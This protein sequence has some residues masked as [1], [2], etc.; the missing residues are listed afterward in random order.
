MY[1]MLNVLRNFDIK[2]LIIF[3]FSLRLLLSTLPP[4]EIDQIGWRAWSMRMVEVGPANFYSKEVFTDNPPGFLYVFWLVG[5]IKNL[6][7]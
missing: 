1:L 5:S 6:M 4:F 2:Y 7:F 3:A